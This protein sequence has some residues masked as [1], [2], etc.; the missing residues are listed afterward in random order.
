MK[1]LLFIGGLLLF[2]SAIWA[3]ARHKTRQAADG[4]KRIALSSGVELEYMETGKPGGI[5]IIFLHG[6][7][8]SWHSF[9]EVLKILPSGFHGFAISQRGH[10]DS[11]SPPTGYTPRDFASDIA[12][13]IKQK[14]LGT[15]IVVGH[16]MGGIHAQQFV[17][18]HPDLAKGI[19]IIASDP[20]FSDNPGMPEF[21][22]EV[23]KMKGTISR[24][25]MED[26]QKATLARP[27]DSAYFELLV[28]E[29]MKPTVEVFQAAF[30]GLMKTDLSSRLAE[31]SKPVLVLWGD[32]DS[33]CD[34][35]GQDQFE[36]G[37]RNGKLIVYQGHGHA[38]HW[39]DPERVVKDI[40]KF[41]ETMAK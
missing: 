32:K 37:L 33:F 28:K 26:F 30:T 40:A 11:E 10:G 21:Y 9:E 39:E 3:A 36:K 13:F 34:K 38:L 2:V 31:I 25:F 24:P 35:P 16:S 8:D 19:V 1:K 20:V 27:I 22:G 18:D 23:M 6:I 17:L 7:C 14:K 5:P 12:A 4:L 15:A 41:S 29:G